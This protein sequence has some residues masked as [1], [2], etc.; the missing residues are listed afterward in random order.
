MPFEF[1]HAA[2]PSNDIAAS[3]AW[4]RKHLGAQVLYQ[5]TTWAFLNVGGTKVALVTPTQHP[6][7]LAVRVTEAELA[8]A[9]RVAGKAIDAHRD[10]TKG[11]YVSDPFGNAIELICYPPGQ[12]VYEKNQGRGITGRSG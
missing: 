5:D 11:I 10:G 4:Y 3:V 9:A 8:D 12:T 7:H 2:V 6:P 1:D